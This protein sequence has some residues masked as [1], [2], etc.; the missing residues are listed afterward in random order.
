MKI[1]FLCGIYDKTIE[2][3]VKT[4]SIS[5]YDIAALEFQRKL[6]NGLKNCYED[7]EV[8]SAPYIGSFPNRYKKAYFNVKKANDITRIEYV[9]FCNIWG[10]RNFSRSYHLKKAINKFVNYD[11]EEKYIIIYAPHT[12][13]MEAA[14]YAEKKDRRIKS[15]L[16]IPDL[17]QFQ[18][19]RSKR[20]SIYRIAKFFDIK[21]FYKLSNN[22]NGFCLLTKKMEDYLY[23]SPKSIIVTP[24][25]IDKSYIKPFNENKKNQ[26][27]FAGN[28]RVD[29]GVLN[30][31]NA[32]EGIEDKTVR[33]VIYGDGQAKNIV[34]ERAKKDPRIE[35]RGNVGQDEVREELYRSKVSVSPRTNDGE[36]TKYS[37]PSKI[38]EYLVCGTTVVSYSL[39]GMP[40]EMKKCIILCKSDSVESLRDALNDALNLSIDEQ[41][42]MWDYS[43]NYLLE[44]IEAERLCRRIIDNLKEF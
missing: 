19:I 38:L 5:G 36:Y 40:E 34:L 39:D 25:I 8:L 32:F 44:N 12:P 13:L 24:G 35:F 15:S 1:L 29:F 23:T 10:I 7:V 26:V 28:L 30:L 31:L 37:F 43:K 21:K 11:D 41:K 4:N 14:A 2:K 20:F 3:K 42:R 22:I 9:P 17:P 33:L 18:N 16:I 27:V 6:Y